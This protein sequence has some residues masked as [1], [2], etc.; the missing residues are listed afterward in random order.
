MEREPTEATA[1]TATHLL[2][3]CV[4]KAETAES[5]L[6]QLWHPS[7]E[8]PDAGLVR[9]ASTLDR[10]LCKVRAFK[11]Q[12]TLSMFEFQN[13]RISHLRELRL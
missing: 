6:A 3:G 10:Y 7:K 11:I 12:E 5:A 2:E 13:F 1:D 9:F 4:S 8:E